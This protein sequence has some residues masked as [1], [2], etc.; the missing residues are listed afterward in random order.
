MI[1]ISTEIL[2]NVISFVFHFERLISQKKILLILT[3]PEGFDPVYKSQYFLTINI[4][5]EGNHFFYPS[6]E[7][8]FAM[9]QHLVS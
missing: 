1:H 8:I 3:S 7:E 4:F 2:V 9:F 6:A 5:P